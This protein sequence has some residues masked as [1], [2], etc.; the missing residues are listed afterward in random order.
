MDGTI[1]KWF[2]LVLLIRIITSEKKGFVSEVL[3]GKK[4][5][6]LPTNRKLY[7]VKS[8]IQCTHHCLQNDNCELLNYNSEEASNDNCEILLQ[9]NG[10]STK[11][12]KEKWKAMRFQVCV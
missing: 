4:F 7:T 6:C 3:D 9:S 5:D 2:F 10:C 8:E 11:L 1:I 12:G